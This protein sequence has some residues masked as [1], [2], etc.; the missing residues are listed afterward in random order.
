MNNWSYVFRILSC[1]IWK[2]NCYW[3]RM[4]YLTKSLKAF[5]LEIARRLIIM[6][7]SYIHVCDLTD[8]KFTRFIHCIWNNETWKL[9]FQSI[10]F[11]LII[12]GDNLILNDFP[13]S[14]W[15]K[16]SE[17]EKGEVN[18]HLSVTFTSEKAFPLPELKV[19]K[20]VRLL[21][22]YW[23]LILSRLGYVFFFC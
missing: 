9:C 13:A 20:H 14:L 10:F 22:V 16:K 5:G 7:M 8:L 21:H 6:E 18:L 17:R 23:L 3:I 15:Q 2:K 11:Y 12:K 1:K 4:E 19:Q